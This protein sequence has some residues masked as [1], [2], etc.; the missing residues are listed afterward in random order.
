MADV[1]LTSY[2]SSAPYLNEEPYLNAGDGVHGVLS[3]VGRQINNGSHT[4]FE[5]VELAID[6]THFVESQLSREISTLKEINS[7]VE[8]RIDDVKTVL[9]QVDR[10]LIGGEKEV[11]EEVTRG[12]VFHGICASSG[13]LEDAYLSVVPYLDSIDLMCAEVW[14]QVEL[15]IDTSKDI[16][17]QVERVV[18]GTKDVLEQFEKRIDTFKD[19][20]SQVERKISEVKDVLEQVERRIDAVHTIQ[21]QVEQR[22]DFVKSVGEQVDRAALKTIFEQVTQV[23][24]N[25]TNLRILCEFPS[26]GV[27]GTNWTA[28][29]TATGDHSINNVNNDLVEKSWRS[30][31]GVLTGISLVCDTEVAQGIFTDTLAILNHNMTTSASVTWQASNDAGFGSVP[32]VQVLT[33]TNNNIY[34]IS[35]NLPTESYRYHRFLIEDATNTKSFIEIGTILFGPSQILQGE[36]F[37]DKIRKARTHFAD[38]LPTEGFTN[39]SNDRALKTAVSFDFRSLDFNKGNYQRLADVFEF[40]RTTLKCLWIP[41]PETPERFAVFGKLAKIPVEEHNVKGADLDYVSFSVTVDEAK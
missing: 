22:I 33:P 19:V 26:R 21:Q 40:A 20:R 28:N 9:E 11:L 3:Q 13:Y 15:R 16:G 10:V 7:Q 37:T 34:W 29:T 8:R 23:L 36:C 2:L 24:Y 31:T 41:T 17:E 38:V 18:D 1:T 5:Q 27:T 4:V 30:A 14:S 39:V 35:E 6:A 12:K 25:T 32:F